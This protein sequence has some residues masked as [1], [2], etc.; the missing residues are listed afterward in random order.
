[1]ADKRKL[2]YE[3]L[4]DLTVANKSKVSFDDWHLWI[5]KDK[6]K[7]CYED[8][9]NLYRTREI[10]F[11]FCEWYDFIY[12]GKKGINLCEWVVLVENNEVDLVYQEKLDY[13]LRCRLGHVEENLE[14]DNIKELIRLE[15]IDTNNHLMA[16]KLRLDSPKIYR[17]IDNSGRGSATTGLNQM[18]NEL[19]LKN[20]SKSYKDCKSTECDKNGPIT[21]ENANVYVL[22]KCG[23]SLREIEKET[24]ISKS[25]VQRSYK[26]LQ[27]EYD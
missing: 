23:M 3:E 6:G 21:S 2:S 14:W 26:Q 13:I 5:K 1:M 12:L 20:G 22:A 8:L 19:K 15:Y 7:L 10:E 27:E 24:G 9:N 4:Y 11:S 17:K 18:I 16:T 25:K